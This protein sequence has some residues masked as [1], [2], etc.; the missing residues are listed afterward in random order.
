[1][2]IK[3]IKRV[4]PRPQYAAMEWLTLGGIIVLADLVTQRIEHNKQIS[5]TTSTKDES[6]N[7]PFH[8]NYSRMQG[9]AVTS[10][11]FL[12]PIAILW[13][14]FL[15][16]LMAKRFSHLAEGTVKYVMTKTVIENVLLPAPVC[17]GYFVIPAAVE[18]GHQWETLPRKLE[19]DFAPSVAVD[20][21]FWCVLSPLNYRFVSVRFQPLFSCVVDGLEAAGLSFLTH[22]DDFKW[23]SLTM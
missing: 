18:G 6:Q 15:H 4:I 16:R 2:V 8:I 19:T 21:A 10:L 5:K 1:M 14:P 20:T 23:P 12:S 9:V 22:C 7:H 17:L 11:G 13:Y 3:M